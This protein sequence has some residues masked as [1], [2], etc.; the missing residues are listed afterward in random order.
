MRTFARLWYRLP[1]ECISHITRLYLNKLKELKKLKQYRHVL[2]A[3]SRVLIRAVLRVQSWGTKLYM[4]VS[5][6]VIPAS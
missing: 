5:S 6:A 3:T 1:D 4:F 2:L